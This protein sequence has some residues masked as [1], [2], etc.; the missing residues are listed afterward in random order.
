VQP[1]ACVAAGTTISCS[2]FKRSYPAKQALHLDQWLQCRQRCCAPAQCA[3]P[4][5]RQ[6]GWCQARTFHND[7]SMLN[8]PPTTENTVVFVSY[9]LQHNKAQTR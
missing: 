7:N 5:A 4:F 1:P 6:M 8:I 9:A 3:L 2:F